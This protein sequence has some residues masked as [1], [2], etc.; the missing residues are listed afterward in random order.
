[1]YSS[2]DRMGKLIRKINMNRLTIFCPFNA[3][4]KNGA[5]YLE[6]QNESVN[7]NSVPLNFCH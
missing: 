6:Q 2:F 1:M 3:A 7:T 4:L 5:R